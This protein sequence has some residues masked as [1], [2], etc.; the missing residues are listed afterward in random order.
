M[1]ADIIPTHDVA[2]WLLSNIDSFL[3]K[4]GLGRNHTTEETLYVAIT[5]VH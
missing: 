4:I 1:L 3:D 5:T 2:V